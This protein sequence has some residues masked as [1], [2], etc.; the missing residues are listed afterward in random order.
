VSF[1]DDE[2]FHIIKSVYDLDVLNECLKDYEGFLTSSISKETPSKCTLALHIKAEHTS[3]STAIKAE[4]MNYFLGKSI[5]AKS[6]NT[7]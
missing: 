3:E 4:F 7:T 5:L 6:G 1:L 2:T